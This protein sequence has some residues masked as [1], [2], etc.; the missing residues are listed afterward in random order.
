M[1]GIARS[2]GYAAAVLLAGAAVLAAPAAAEASAALP[3]PAVVPRSG[4]ALV[5]AI[6]NAKSARFAV[7]RLSRGC[8]YILT[9]AVTGDD[10]LPP[11]SPA[12]S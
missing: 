5:T 3:G 9:S 8:N 2:P 6:Q 10:G 4:S 11:R 7:L 12:R 1:P